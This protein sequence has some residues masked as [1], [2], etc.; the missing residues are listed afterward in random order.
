ME[1]E[2]EQAEACSPWAL[3]HGP[4]GTQGYDSQALS[5]PPPVGL[6]QRWESIFGQLFW[7]QEVLITLLLLCRLQ[8]G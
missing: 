3:K 2:M 6:D 7:D 4:L 8:P 5:V 1:P